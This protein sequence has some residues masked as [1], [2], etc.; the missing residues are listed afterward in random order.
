MNRRYELQL[1]ADGAAGE[2]TAPAAATQTAPN[3]NGQVVTDNGTN[4]ENITPDGT[5]TQQAPSEPETFESLINGKY[6]AEFDERVQTIV[7]NRLK[8]SRKSE[9]NL[10]KL[11]P[12][13]HMLG[14]KYGLD[15]A[16]LNYEELSQKI[17][18]DNSFYEKEALEKGID[19]NEL[20]RIKA[21]E[22]E[23]A[24]LKERQRMIMREQESRRQFDA[25]LNQVPGVQQMYPTF[26]L[27]TEMSNPTFLKL[28]NDGISVKNAFEVIHQSELQPAVMQAVA[29][30]TNEQ[31][32]NAIKSNQAR[33]NE[34]TL[35][36]SAAD[37]KIDIKSMSVKDFKDIQRRVARGEKI[38]MS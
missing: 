12:A 16:N 2:G 1:F 4:G 30:K 33:P 26:D 18:D 34:S 15:V 29:Q 35:N 32:T 24:S 17:A 23:N 21:V 8:N 22:R 31:L 14:E 19:I 25:I 13:L 9:D 28:V 6:K 10:A 3:G 37:F 5:A 20:K 27:N 36:S 7:K 11:Q 38:T